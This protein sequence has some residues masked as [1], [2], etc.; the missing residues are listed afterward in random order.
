MSQ[1]ELFQKYLP[2]FNEIEITQSVSA[3]GPA[4]SVIGRRGAANIFIAK[5][6]TEGGGSYPPIVMNRATARA[7]RQALEEQ[8]F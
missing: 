3:N 8:G 1:E 4:V 7:L 6:A 5:F 2:T